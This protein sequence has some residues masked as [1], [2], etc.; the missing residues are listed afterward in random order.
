M[1]LASLCV[2]DWKQ[3]CAVVIPCFNEQ[4]GL[5]KLLPKILQQLPT[6][7]V[8][9]D[10]SSDDTANVAKAQGAILVSLPQNQGKGL[11]LRAGCNL[12]TTLGFKW[13]LT[14]DGD[15]QH[16]PESIYDFL[17]HAQ[18]TGADLVVGNRMEN[19]E[20][21]PWLRRK[22]NQVL[23][24]HLSKLVGQS[25]PDTQC[26]YRLIRLE[27]LAACELSTKR[28]EIESELLVQMALLGKRV[29]FIP[30]ATIYKNEQSKI[31]PFRDSL[32]WFCWLFSVRK[33]VAAQPLPE[34]RFKAS[35][36]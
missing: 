4:H 31:Q 3:Q 1:N 35:Q 25:L 29:D 32:R 34:E 2:M 23:S 21:M 7:I 13:V 22:T 24:S 14:M 19:C 5:P 17:T 30:I 33:Q 20:S 11:A 18:A 27:A 28:F 10:G 36:A 12:A 15:G 26:G 16:G 9:D 8:I 6:V